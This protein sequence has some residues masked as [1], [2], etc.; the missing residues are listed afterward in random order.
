MPHDKLVLTNSSRG[1]QV[2]C[3]QTIWSLFFALL[4]FASDD[5]HI[6]STLTKIMQESAIEVLEGRE[7]PIEIQGFVG[8]LNAID[9]EE[10]FNLK[11]GDFRIEGDTVLA[12]TRAKGLFR[13]KGKY[14]KDCETVDVVATLEVDLVPIVEGKV[15]KRGIGF[16]IKPSVKNMELKVRIWELSPDSLVDGNAL[17]TDFI[18]EVYV[19]RKATVLETINAAIVEKKLDWWS[20]LGSNVVSLGEDNMGWMS[21]MI[22]IILL[23]F[24][25]EQVIAQDSQVLRDILSRATEKA[26]SKHQSKE[27]A[28]YSEKNSTS[29]GVIRISKETKSWL[30]LDD[31]GKNLKIDITKLELKGDALSFGVTAKGK[32]KGMAWGKISNLFEADVKLSANVQI[33]IEGKA[34]IENGR[35][36]SVEISKLW[37]EVKDLCFNND[38]LNAAQD[39]VEECVNSYIVYK[40]DDLKKELKKA[41]EKFKE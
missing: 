32:A 33:V 39:V 27:T 5:R 12:I 19:A 6:E 18:Y 38:A 9:P 25:G 37:G 10:K 26:L 20:G 36:T 23:T 24:S 21:A 22:V 8:T 13:L 3:I 16:Y 7:F 2:N 4:P 41:I 35:F 30:W 40:N 31:P 28:W 17:F 1:K 29:G 34:R 11:V 15:Y 14:T